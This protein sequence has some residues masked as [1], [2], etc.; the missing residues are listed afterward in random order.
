[1]IEPDS[2]PVPVQPYPVPC[3]QLSTYK[4][5]LDHLC[6]PVSSFLNKRANG[7]VPPS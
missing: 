5:E 4:H 6:D 7:Q 3:I 1:V 2:K